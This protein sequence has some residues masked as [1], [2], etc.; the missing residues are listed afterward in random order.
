MIRRLLVPIGRPA[1]AQDGRS[2]YGQRAEASCQHENHSYLAREPVLRV[3]AEQ[4]GWLD[5]WLGG[6][7]PPRSR[8]PN[9]RNAVSAATTNATAAPR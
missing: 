4:F 5:W 1:S 8:E 7:A 9:R 6:Q 2:R 3:L